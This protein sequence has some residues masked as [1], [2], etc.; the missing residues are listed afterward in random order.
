MASRPSSSSTKGK[1]KGAVTVVGPWLPIGVLFLRSRACSELS[2]VGTK[3]LLDACSLLMENARGNGDI[4]L[5]ESFLVG[6][7]WRS[8]ATAQAAVRELLDARLLS[9]TRQ[10]GRRKCSL[11][12]VTL[13]PLDCDFTKLDHG[14]AVCSGIDWQGRNGER[15]PAPTEEQPAIWRAARRDPPRKA[16]TENAI[17]TPATGVMNRVMPPPRGNRTPVEPS[18]AP[19]TGVVEPKEADSVPPPRGTFLDKPSAV[20]FPLVASEMRLQVE[21]LQPT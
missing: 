11:Y 9:V 21:V 8:K 17:G 12:A 19:A 14:P 16:P 5:T 10:G 15:A 1:R 18:Y 2:P 13:W 6:R 4:S 3:M 7:G 20:A